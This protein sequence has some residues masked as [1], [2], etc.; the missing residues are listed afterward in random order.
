[1]HY[2]TGEEEVGFDTAL[3]KV[4]FP[5]TRMFTVVAMS[6][7][8]DGS[9]AVSLVSHLWPEGAV[10]FVDYYPNTNGEGLDL[11]DNLDLMPFV[12]GNKHVRFKNTKGRGDGGD[13]NGNN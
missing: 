6:I 12:E 11:L 3:L 7:F 4:K 5:H 9:E 2:Y 1:M 8:L 13:N 10:C